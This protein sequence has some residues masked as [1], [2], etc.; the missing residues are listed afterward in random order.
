MEVNK[1][2]KDIEAELAIFTGENEKNMWVLGKPD[3]D[4]LRTVEFNGKE[5]G[6]GV[7]LGS[8]KEVPGGYKVLSQYI[9]LRQQLG[10]EIPGHS[11]P[12]VLISNPVTDIAVI[13]KK[14]VATK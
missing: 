14:E 12:I 8:I 5:K 3:K 10:I 7:L 13:A 1:A 11:E 9:K 6:Q 4:G 2:S